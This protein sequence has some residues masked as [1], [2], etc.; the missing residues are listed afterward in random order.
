VKAV[1]QRQMAIPV[2]SHNRIHNNNLIGERTLF[3]KKKS[4]YFMVRHVGI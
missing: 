2:C 3:K 1:E 4:T